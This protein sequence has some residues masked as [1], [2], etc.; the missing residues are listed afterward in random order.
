M[1]TQPEIECLRVLV[2]TV[3]SHVNKNGRSRER[4]IQMKIVV[5]LNQNMIFI[6]KNLWSSD[7]MVEQGVCCAVSL[8]IK[9]TGYRVMFAIQPCP[10]GTSFHLIISSQRFFVLCW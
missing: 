9:D 6:Q 8:K 5:K 3:S 1:N 10:P 4:N 7:E 2:C